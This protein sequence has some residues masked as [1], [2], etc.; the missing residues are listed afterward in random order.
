MAFLVFFGINL[1]LD[2]WERVATRI[3]SS[4]KQAMAMAHYSYCQLKTRLSSPS[5]QHNQCKLSTICGII[6]VVFRSGRAMFVMCLC[7]ILK[8]QEGKG[9]FGKNPYR[10]MVYVVSSQNQLVGASYHLSAQRGNITTVCPPLA[11]YPC[12][13]QA[14][15]LYVRFSSHIQRHRTLP[16]LVAG[17]DQVVCQRLDGLRCV[18]SLHILAVV[19]N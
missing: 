14:W 5:T 11:E 7:R 6:Y 16:G 8:S 1:A 10:P 18:S 9:W 12:I 19:T 3:I 13:L 4:F 15:S 17:L 2:G